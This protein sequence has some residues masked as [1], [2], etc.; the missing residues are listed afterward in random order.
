M[1]RIFLADGWPATKS[2]VDVPY[3]YAPV[4]IGPTTYVPA[5]RHTVDGVPVFT[6]AAKPEAWPT[7][8]TLGWLAPKGFEVHSRQ[9][10][11][12]GLW[13]VR[14]AALGLDYHAV[15]L[16]MV[17][18]SDAA[19]VQLFAQLEDAAERI[20]RAHRGRVRGHRP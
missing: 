6:P 16:V 15:G 10:P 4:R 1:A 8:A 13:Y 2:Y 18:D 20:A 7:E 19:R 9:C 14:L 3:A 11:G 12:C 5:D 17:R